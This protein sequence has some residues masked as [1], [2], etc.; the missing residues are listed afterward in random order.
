MQWA[1]W[2]LTP[3]LP[4]RRT[5]RQGQS[6]I[7]FTLANPTCMSSM[8]SEIRESPA[9]RFGLG[10]LSTNSTNPKKLGGISEKEGYFQIFIKNLDGKSKSLWVQ[11][12][13]LISGLK[14]KIQISTGISVMRQNSSWEATTGGMS[15][16]GLLHPKELFHRSDIDLTLRLKG[17]AGL[18]GGSTSTKTE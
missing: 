15:I 10:G 6:G 2:G 5:R 14:E 1:D 12:T 18:A 16:K 3:W 7:D 4:S 17:G 8:L 9:G 11:E 13:D